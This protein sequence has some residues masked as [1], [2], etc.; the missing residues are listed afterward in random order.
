MSGTWF[1]YAEA[2]QRLGIK[3]DSV[4]KRAMRRHWPRTIGND[5][6]TRIQ[7][8]EDSPETVPTDITRDITGDVSPPADDTRERLAASEARAEVLAAQ[9]QDL[10]R[11]RDRLLGLL[12]TR[13]VGF[14]S[15]LFNRL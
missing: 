4:K 7:L 3:P 2:A 15:R 6:K 11:E 10:Q 1:T 13:P 8:P 5:G 12:E 14:L 9:V